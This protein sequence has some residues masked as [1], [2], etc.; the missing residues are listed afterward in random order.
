MLFNK[1]QFLKNIYIAF[2][3]K[4]HLNDPNRKRGE[5]NIRGKYKK[6]VIPA[7]AE[8][9]FVSIRLFLSA[10]PQQ[11]PATV[12]RNKKEICFPFFIAAEKII[13]NLIVYNILFTLVY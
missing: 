10:A 1:N 9:C 7:T 8:L 5:K 11:V 12:K 2:S 4:K 3:G 6:K 13:E